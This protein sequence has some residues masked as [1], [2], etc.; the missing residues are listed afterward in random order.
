MHF[1]N[2]SRVFLIFFGIY[3]GCFNLLHSQEGFNLPK[4]QKR[5]KISFKNINNLVIIPVEVNG[6]SLSFLLDT[7]VSSTII[8]SLGE[9]D[10]LEI[11]NT[12]P[13]K[14]RGMG[15]G[16]VIDAFKS[17]NNTV[18]IGDAIDTNHDLYLIFDKALNFSPRMGIP[19]HGI[20]GYDFFNSF[21]VKTN[22]VS[23]KIIIYDPDNY[24]KRRC[25]GCQDFDME[26]H[27]NK[28][29]IDFTIPSVNSEKN[30]SHLL[31]DTGLSDSVWLFDENSY[32][33]EDYFDDFLGLGLSGDIY[34]KRSKLDI[35]GIGKFSLENVTVAFPKKDAI[36][37]AL[38]HE[39]RDG[40][41]GGG[42]IKRFISI[43]D[44]QK[45][46]ITLK[47]NK[48]FKD[49]FF[50]NMSGLTLEH[51]GMKVVKNEK[52]R[53]GSSDYSLDGQKFSG[54]TGNGV[55]LVTD[56]EL[57][58]APRFIVAD[59]RKN[60]PADLAGI[61]VGTEILK[62]NGKAAHSY[63]LYEIAKLFSS[64]SGKTISLQIQQ[65]GFISKVKFIL[66]KVI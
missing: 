23:E 12:K 37:A 15:D 11:R 55:S 29:Y 25:G 63:K 9:K 16:E 62:V 54:R 45:K 22:Y 7:G 28:P 36:E 46:T 21:V 49:E 60:S 18:K 44:Y 40:S 13:V 50:Y 27:K 52:K 39:K 64:K 2:Y 1:L 35:L 33:V 20:I 66:K 17:S 30:S 56:I 51:N 48:N 34:G 4:N 65:Y 14:I 53:V 5:D 47:K 31:L 58:L 19:V 57:V 38:K 26:F 6:T 8:F 42:I 61:V 3:I 32:N 43:I 41:V 10:S 24:R 59:V